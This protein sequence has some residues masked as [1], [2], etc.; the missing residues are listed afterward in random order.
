MPPNV[1]SPSETAPFFPAVAELAK[2]CGEFG[3]VSATD[4]RVHCV[5]SV[6]PDAAF[7]LAVEEAKLWVSWVSPN[8]YL[9]QSI[10]A[11]VKWTGDDIDEL[12]AE[13]LGERDL[14][15]VGPFQHF[16]NEDKQFVFRSE[17]PAGLFRP[18]ADGA[19]VGLQLLL[20][21]QAAFRNLGDMKPEED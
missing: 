12:I 19:A 9:S 15:K 4:D 7:R 18:G 3:D 13:E 6:Q 10:E 20:A 17:L 2:R 21:Y 16:R 1:P 11:E 8:R 5:D 14:P